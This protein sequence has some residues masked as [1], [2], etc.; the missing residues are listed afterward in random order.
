[1][2]STRPPLPPAPLVP[3]AS[4]TSV[5]IPAELIPERRGAVAFLSN[6]EREGDWILPRLFRVVSFMGNVE[7]DLTSVR[8][9]PGESHIEIRCLW[10]NVEIT[11]PP[12]IRIEADGHP[13]IGSFELKRSLPST[14]S[15]D[16]PVLRISGSVV[17]GAVTIKVKGR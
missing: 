14:Q 17:M 8:L 9:G 11:V 7:L 12:E 1:M 3:H 10:G 6:F 15:A 13:F 2:T 16:A 4:A 5:V